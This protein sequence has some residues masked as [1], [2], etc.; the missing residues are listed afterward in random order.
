MQTHDQKQ[1][2]YAATPSDATASEWRGYAR[3]AGLAALTVG[4]GA[5]AANADVVL[6]PGRIILNSGAPDSIVTDGTFPVSIT[7][8]SGKYKTAFDFDGD[9]L[10]DLR[11]GIGYYN[12]AD[13]DLGAR[14]PGQTMFSQAFTAGLA[15]GGD[16][17]DPNRYATAFAPG[18]LIDG[19]SA[20]ARVIYG[21]RL[22]NGASFDDAT[23]DANDG[24]FLGFRTT[25]G[26]FGYLEFLFETDI[27]SSP[28]PSGGPGVRITFLSSAIETT[29]GVGIAAGAVP[30]VP[31]PS[32]VML[33]AAGAAGLA[34]RRGG[35]RRSA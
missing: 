6:N 16:G 12:Q 7:T 28:T 9:G 30:A 17:G 27:A 29:P 4:A 22:I 5:T 20:P 8:P 23:D 11:V 24:G 13:L 33:L 1:T 21:S 26:L 32:S 10:Q 14:V 31:E 19:S 35:K 25:T 15:T 3:A 34:V 2:L 18:A